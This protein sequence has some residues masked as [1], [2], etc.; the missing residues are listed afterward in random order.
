[1]D[2]VSDAAAVSGFDGNIDW[3]TWSGKR[4]I[5]MLL[6]PICWYF[7]PDKRSMLWA[8]NA[9]ISF[10]STVRGTFISIEN[11]SKVV[12]RLARPKRRN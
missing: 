8:E 5:Q 10:L 4:G 6:P 11:G 7:Q 2:L 12:K 1:M 3:P 9:Q